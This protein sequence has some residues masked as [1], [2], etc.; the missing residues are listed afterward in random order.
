V[1]HR[2]KFKTK[3]KAWYFFGL[4]NP[5]EVKWKN[6]GKEGVTGK[7]GDRRPKLTRQGKKGHGKKF[8][9]KE[10]APDLMGGLRKREKPEE[11]AGKATHSNFKG[12]GGGRKAEYL[13]GAKVCLLGKEGL[14]YG[15]DTLEGDCREIQGV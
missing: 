1:S 15:T 6:E 10:I 12:K 14:V 9:T 3:R 5:C 2:R 7:T 11:T 4:R 8:G 13:R